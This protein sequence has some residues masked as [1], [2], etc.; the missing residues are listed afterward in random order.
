MKANTRVD[1]TN[2]RLWIFPFSIYLALAAVANL[3]T[4]LVGRSGAEQS[5]FAAQSDSTI[6]VS[7][8]PLTRDVAARPG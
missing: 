2:R 8:Y 5:E 3:Y 6:D 7:R 4:W 1:R